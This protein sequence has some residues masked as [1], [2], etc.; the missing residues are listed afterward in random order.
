AGPSRAREPAS[1]APPTATVTKNLRQNV[2]AFTGA[3]RMAH[4]DPRPRLARLTIVGSTPRSA[5]CGRCA[6]VSLVRWNEWRRRRRVVA[7]GGD[8]CPDLRHR[9]VEVVP[10]EHHLG[11][12]RRVEEAEHAAYDGLTRRVRDRQRVRGGLNPVA[13]DAPGTRLGVDRV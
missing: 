8:Q 2:K 12:A 11:R 13:G 1:A 4:G 3:T 10:R 6:V 5:P 9:R 7:S